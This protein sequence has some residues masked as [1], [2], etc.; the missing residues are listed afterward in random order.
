MSIY[1]AVFTKR[2]AIIKVISAHDSQNQ[3]VLEQ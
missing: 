3:G 2:G 1:K